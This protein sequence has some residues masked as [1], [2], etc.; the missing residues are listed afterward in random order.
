MPSHHDAW[1]RHQQS[2]WLRPDAA[3]WVRPDAA[4]FL[5][6]GADIAK[7]FLRWRANTVRT[8]RACRPEVRMAA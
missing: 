7:A 8:S 6:P 4:R 5:P 2:R 1:L 3:R